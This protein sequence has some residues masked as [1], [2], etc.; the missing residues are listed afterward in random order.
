MDWVQLEPMFTTNTTKSGAAASVGAITGEFV[1]SGYFGGIPGDPDGGTTR[2]VTQNRAGPTFWVGKQANGSKFTPYWDKIG[3]VGHY[4]YGSLTMARTLGSDPNQVAVNGR[5]VLIGWI[6]GG[7]PAS[8]SLARDLTLS[9]NYELLQQFVPELQML[10]IPSSHAQIAAVGGTPAVAQRLA[11]SLQLEVVATFSWSGPNPTQPFGVSVLG[12]A[13]NLTVDC[14]AD[15]PTAPKADGGCQVGVPGHFGPLMPIGTTTVNV[16]A[17]VDHQIVETIFNNRTAMVTY[18]MLY[19]ENAEVT[20]FGLDDPA[21][22]VQ[23]DTWVLK[24][25]NNFGPQP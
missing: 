1:T 7:N 24:D 15:Q 3:A 25:A 23:L 21:I 4:D 14:T 22:H 8:Q 19:N 17:I 16:H 2:V 5:R 9:P 20:T 12:G 11:G 13:A 6:G 18:A 10:R